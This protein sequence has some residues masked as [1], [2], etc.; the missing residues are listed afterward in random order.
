[1]KSQKFSI[2]L[3][4]LTLLIFFVY[5]KLPFS[6]FQQDEWLTFGGFLNSQNNG[7][8]I[9][10]FSNT[11]ANSGGVHIVPLSAV[12][13]YLQI[14]IF[15]LN[16][17]SYAVLSIL[18]HVINTLLVI[19]LAKIIFKKNPL[20]L[21]A[22]II[23]GVSSIASQAVIWIA[24][25]MV[26]QN[27]TTFLLLSLIFFLKFIDSQNNKK[28]LISALAMAFIGL[29]F[30]ESVF[31]LFIL[32]PILLLLWLK[33]K[34][35]ALRFSLPF[36]LSGL[37]YFSLR[38]PSYINSLSHSY[39]NISDVG[40]STAPFA[41]VARLLILPF[42]IISQSLIPNDIMMWLS[43]KAIRY[44]YP[45]IFIAEDGYIDG[46]VQESIAFDF[47]SLI[48]SLIII[49]VVIF[50]YKIYISK[51]D[52]N[53]IKALVFSLFLIVMSGLPLVLI[54][55]RPG[56]SSIFEPRHL[57]IATI[58]SSILITLLLMELLKGKRKRFF[59]YTL[60]AF[61]LF[62]NIRSI[63]SD[64]SYQKQN[65]KIRQTILS[66]IQEKYPKLPGKV[67]FY[68]ESDTAYYGLSE[69]EKIL[70]FQ[71]GFGQTLLVWYSFH[72]NKFPPCFFEDTFLY[73]IDEEGYKFCQGRGFGYFRKIDNLKKA[74]AENEF[75]L[76]NII[77]F[78]WNGTSE[79]LIDVTK[80]TRAVL[81]YAANKF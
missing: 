79:R 64:L 55:D 51:K 43:E 21:I 4:L 32:F 46:V 26:T 76:D 71:S 11:I 57:Y 47:L 3:M 37:A 58:G 27:S 22:G 16:F 80:E 63:R 19:Y 30:K 54:S 42:R 52:L 39:G 44:L 36:I 40:I 38:I 24:T 12:R 25:S 29:L 18:N 41:Y 78:R 65:G 15:H 70:P 23:F 8:L 48:L 75:N 10:F 74:I 56:F 34:K 28:Y 61:L 35:K 73:Q 62:W 9:K 50:L 2:Y 53:S 45:H 14:A 67:I 33:E 49:I 1:M 66:T 31:F 72:E 77:S 20:S 81:E 5:A 6:F 60:V 13:S 68:V 59:F 69:S 7:G 17:Y